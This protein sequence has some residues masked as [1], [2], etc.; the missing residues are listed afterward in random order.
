MKRLLLISSL[1]IVVG[2]SEQVSHEPADVQEIKTQLQLKET[3]ERDITIADFEREPSEWGENV[4][5][6]KTKFRTD[7]QEIA[8]TF[9]ACG[10][11][12]GSGYDEELISFLRAEH[13]SA[14]LFVNERW[15]LENE[16]LFL[17][18]AADPLFDIENHG[19]EHAPLSVAGGEAWGITA[20]ASAEEAYREI[21]QN[22]LR[23]KELTGH[24]MTMFRSGTA[25]YDEVA[26]ELAN[27]LGYEVVNFNILGDAGATFSSEKVREA[28]LSSGAG[29][30][31]LLHMNQPTSGTADGVREAV[32][33]LQEQGYEFILLRDR[34]LE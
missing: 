13:V 15:I 2:C 26:V 18:L 3:P 16:E 23:V 9:D 33:L 27:A 5:G 17:E 22:H 19:T 24:E 28:L 8:L 12:H 10:G 4:T 34:E 11:P 30:I 32:P 6:V 31:A 20:T 29:S 7:K 21:M 25:Y 1:L 14:T